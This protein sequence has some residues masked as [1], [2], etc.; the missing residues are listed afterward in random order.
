MHTSIIF[1][2]LIQFYFNSQPECN[3]YECAWDGFDCSLHLSPW[4]N[5]TQKD[6]KQCWNVF[7]DGQCNQECN[8]EKCLFD[9]WDCNQP[10][11]SCP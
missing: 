3:T 7:N 2:Y 9:G 4:S 5:C 1:S 6:G 8:S 11:A 10:V